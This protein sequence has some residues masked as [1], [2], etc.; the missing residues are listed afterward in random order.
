MTSQRVLAW[1][2]EMAEDEEWD[3]M[4]AGSQVVLDY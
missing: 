3:K 2:D 4:L 1:M